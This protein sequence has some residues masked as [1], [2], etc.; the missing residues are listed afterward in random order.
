MERI[1]EVDE[2]RRQGLGNRMEAE[3]GGHESLFGLG[4]V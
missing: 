1:N 4:R 2:V 3:G